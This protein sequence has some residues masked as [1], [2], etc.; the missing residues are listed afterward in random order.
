M[1]MAGGQSS[2]MRAD[3]GKHHK[4]LRTVAGMTLFEHNLFSLLH[5]GFT[6][7]VIA[8]SHSEKELNDYLKQR[9]LPLTQGADYQVTLYEEKEPHGTIGAARSVSAEHG[10]VP[11]INVDNLS[12][13]DPRAFLNSHLENG[14]AMT[15]ATHYQSFRMPFGEVQIKDGFITELCEKPTTVYH[16]SSGTYVLSPRARAAIPH[17]GPL[18]APQLFEILK[19][20]GET[21]AAW[22]HGCHWIDIND[23]EGLELAEQMI[24]THKKQFLER[25]EKLELFRQMQGAPFVND[26]A[27]ECEG[28]RLL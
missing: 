7:L 27:R 10:H 5:G 12:D 14:A 1:I 28:G 9:I 17:T 16:T 21:V 13:M 26:G 25:F 6:D 18:G 23:T 20:K 15:I 19:Q 4:A 24:S 8:T 2:R 11:V 22:Q 3:G